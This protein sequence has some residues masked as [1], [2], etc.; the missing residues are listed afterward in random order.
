MEKKPTIRFVSEG[1]TKTIHEESLRILQEVG[2]GVD[3]EKARQ[4]LSDHGA[5]VDSKNG[6]VKFPERLI[7]WAVDQV[8]KRVVYGASN[9][10]H[11][12]ILEP[13]GKTY[14]R[15]PSGCEGYVDIKSNKWRK[16]QEKDLI[17]ATKL[18]DALENVHICGGI[19]PEDVPLATRDVHI[20]AV[21][22]EHTDKHLHISPYSGQSAH[23]IADL[24]LTL[25]SKD[26]FKKRPLVSFLNSSLSPLY[27]QNSEIETFFA[28]AEYGIPVELDSMPISGATGPVTIGGN[29]A[30]TNAELLAGIAIIQTVNPG[31]PLL[32]APR[33]MNM[34]MR[35]GTAL[36]SSIEN[37]IQAA[38]EVQLVKEQYGIL[39]NVFGMGTD[40]LIPDGQSVLERTLNT[41]F[42]LFAG[43]TILTGAGMLEHHYTFSPV[44]L[45]ID[46]EMHG[47]FD[48]FLTRFYP[49]DEDILGSNAIKEVGIRGTFFTHEH[50]MRYFRSEYYMSDLFER[51]ARDIWEKDGAKD[52]NDRARDMALKILREH[53]APLLEERVI[54]ELRAKLAVIEQKGAK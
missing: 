40:S 30:L 51:R 23:L 39:T 54:K 50:T 26:E 21:M 46:N 22:L 28:A 25:V 35:T 52:I 9:A 15:S 47:M 33:S 37:A 34:D 38:I 32:Y 16:V 29:V 8:P 43:A 2:V 13:E 7:Q 17:E 20:I 31:T 36:S 42:P 6:V 24:L 41:L 12:I 44:Q 27:Y 14:I 48:R 11:D 19:S 49:I 1:A 10:E 45:I 18:V 3:N 4:I 53:Q 5:R